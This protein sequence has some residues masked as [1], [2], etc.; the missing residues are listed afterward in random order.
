[1]KY[2][3]HHASKL[4]WLR[5]KKKRL[6]YS[7]HMRARKTKVGECTAYRSSRE[8]TRAHERPFFIYV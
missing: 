6:K 5:T 3:P 1:M 4:K 2:F 8:L 7:S